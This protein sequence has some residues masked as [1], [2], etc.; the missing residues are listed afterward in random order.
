M[1]IRPERLSAIPSIILAAALIANPASGAPS[2]RVHGL[3]QLPVGLAQAVEQELGAAAPSGSTPLAQQQELVASNAASNDF[4]GF[5]VA[6]SNDGHIA[7]VGAVGKNSNKGAAYIFIKHAD[8]WTEQQELT[9][10]DGESEDEFGISVALDGCGLLALIGAPGKNSGK[11]AAFIFVQHGTTYRQQ[12]ELTA[13]GGAANDVFG[14]SVA[15][16]TDEHTALIGA[17]GKHASTGAAYIFTD[18]PKNWTEQQELKASDGE[19]ADS[20]GYAVALNS[21]GEIA[22]IGAPGKDSSTGAAYIFDH[23]HN[24]WT[25]QQELKASDAVIDDGFGDAVAL[26]YQGRI[27]LIGAP[28]KNADEGAAYIFSETL[29]TYLQQQELRASDATPYGDYFGH[30]VALDAWGHIALIGAPARN[31]ETGAAYIFT[32]NGNSYTQQQELTAS[33]GAMFDQFGYS[34]ALNYYGQI[35][36]IGA[37]YTNTGAAY[38]FENP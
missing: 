2:E 33:D 24:T 28:F 21:D 22:L 17:P 8:T 20:F 23:G 1:Q 29:N 26:N 14:T 6:L 36:L 9:A 32:E 31:T 12:Q 4:F 13:A 15:L 3:S 10:L 19:N 37:P 25:E 34:V 5:S 30:A 18:G 38:M 27:A 16:S 7:L 11:G 35:A